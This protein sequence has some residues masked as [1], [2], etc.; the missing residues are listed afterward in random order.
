MK[1]ISKLISFLLVIMV[2]FCF[3]GSAYANEITPRDGFSWSHT[4]SDP[5]GGGGYGAYGSWTNGS[6]VLDVILS[7]ITVNV[8][9]EAISRLIPGLS[10]E[11]L[12]SIAADILSDVGGQLTTPMLYYRVCVAYHNTLP[13]FYKKMEFRWY[14]DAA[15]TNELTDY[16]HIVYAFKA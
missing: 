14:S 15:R 7:N 6:T 8:L 5:S 1:R 11:E 9:A 13:G 2:F 10:T 3:T 12:R 4:L 16:P